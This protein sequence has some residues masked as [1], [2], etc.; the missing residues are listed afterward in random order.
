MVMKI[1]EMTETDMRLS[2]SD[3][4]GGSLVTTT[5]DFGATAQQAKRT[6]A[7][8]AETRQCLAGQIFPDR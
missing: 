6:G 7:G 1:F 5:P 4:N 8:Y 3:Q 2:H